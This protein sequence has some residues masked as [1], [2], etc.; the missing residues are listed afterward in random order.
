VL[1]DSGIDLPFIIVSGT[2]GEAAAVEAMRS[3]AHDF[4]PKGALVRLLP[5]I[6]RE[7]REAIVRN[8]RAQ[9][10]EQLLIAE[11]MA[12]VGTLAASVAHEINNPLTVVVANLDIIEHYIS[13]ITPSKE[14]AERPPAIGASSDTID[15]GQAL[16]DAQ[17]AAARV[18]QITRDLRIFSRPHEDERLE[19]VELRNVL[20]SSIRMASNEI[21]HRARLVKVFGDVPPVEA[22]EARLGQVFLNL[23]VNAAHAIPEGR[24]E[25]NEIRITTSQDDTGRVIIEV[26]DTGVGIPPELHD[27]IFSAFFTTKTASVGTGLG[28][29]ICQRIIKSLGGEISF[30]SELGKGTAFRVAVMPAAGTA[31]KAKPEL[32]VTGGGRRGRLLIVDDEPMLS[33]TLKTVLES[34]HEVVI[35]SG[36]KEAIAL[37]NA[38]EPF[39]VILTD[40]MMP[41]MTGMEFHAHLQRHSPDQ[42][43]KMIFMTGGAFSEDAA[44]FLQSIPNV[45]IEKPFTARALRAL[46]RNAVK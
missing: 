3:G 15:I 21:R 20:E 38:G 1:K 6:E 29:A 2:I 11:R 9:M 36:A 35:A 14:S 17:E 13:E 28:L 16:R 37:I 43:H 42:V 24:T 34:E 23:I 10:R 26:A 18:R 4:L 12:S 46:V 33:S 19:P 45:T 32:E 30:T 44:S 8:E 5:A 31:S 41:I 40:L 39:D 27:R 7:L 25:D 22:N